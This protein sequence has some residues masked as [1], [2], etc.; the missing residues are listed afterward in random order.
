MGL[1]KTARRATSKVQGGDRG[2]RGPVSVLTSR[3]LYLTSVKRSQVKPE[4]HRLVGKSKA[5]ADAHTGAG[6]RQGQNLTERSVL[7]FPSRGS[8]GHRTQS[9]YVCSAEAP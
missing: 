7:P 6:T 4:T 3:G 9:S 8:G 1:G 2:V 5:T